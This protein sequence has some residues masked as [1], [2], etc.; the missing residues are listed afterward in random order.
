M[1]DDAAYTRPGAPDPARS[2]VRYCNHRYGHLIARI[3]A[4]GDTEIQA[5]GTT[6]ND[7]CS[8]QDCRLIQFSARSRTQ[9]TCPNTCGMYRADALRVT[10]LC[11]LNMHI[12]DLWHLYWPHD[13]GRDTVRS[14]TGDRLRGSAR[15]SMT[16]RGLRPIEQG[17]GQCP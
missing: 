8:R 13:H 7:R 1:L 4:L 5:Q 12:G 11:G 16:C 3:A 2:L 6:P 10:I 9:W 17:V 15:P 14:R